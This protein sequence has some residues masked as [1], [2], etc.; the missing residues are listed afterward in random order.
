MPKIAEYLRIIRK[1]PDPVGTE[2]N[3]RGLKTYEKEN[4]KSFAAWT[5][6][7]SRSIPI[8]HVPN[9]FFLMG[10]SFRIKNLI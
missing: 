5:L 8:A 6:R 3:W 7:T 10:I 1:I 4:Q 9:S 2:S